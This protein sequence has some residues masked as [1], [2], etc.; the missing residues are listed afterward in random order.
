VWKLK[1]E[2]YTGELR[3]TIAIRSSVGSLPEHV[4]LVM[5]D[6]D[7]SSWS[8][9]SITDYC[10]TVRGTIGIEM[11]CH[12]V[13]VLTAG[14]GR[15]SGLGFTVDSESQNEYLARL[16]NIHST[17]PLSPKQVELARRFAYALFRRRPWKATSFQI[18][19]MEV[20]ATGHPLDQNV[21]LALRD[22][23][24]FRKAADLQSFSDWVESDQVDYLSDE[25]D[26]G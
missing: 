25:Q 15:Y 4:K 23:Q 22:M 14:T 7:I 16:A 24:G 19:K 10:I 12:G 13:P 26:F 17:P 20:N 18:V 6:T 11:A 9:F 3:D 8:F 21:H 2:G 1:Y 5:P